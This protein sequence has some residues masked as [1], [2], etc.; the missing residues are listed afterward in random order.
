MGYG[1]VKGLQVKKFS[2]Y[3]DGDIEEKLNEFFIQNQDVEIVDVQYKLVPNGD[4]SDYGN[5][6]AL[7]FYR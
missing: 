1:K 2:D 4:L 5:E 7:V 6:I 3:V